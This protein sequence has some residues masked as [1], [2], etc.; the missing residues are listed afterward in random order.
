M[1]KAGAI[2][3][4]FGNAKEVADALRPAMQGFGLT[5]WEAL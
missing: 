3:S 1:G 4:K 2:D 5:A